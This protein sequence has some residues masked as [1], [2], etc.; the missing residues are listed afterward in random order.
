MNVIDFAANIFSSTAALISFFFKSFS[1][2]LAAIFLVYSLVLVKQTSVMTRVLE[3]KN[4]KA[5]IMI[6]VIQTIF[7]FI[8]LVMAISLI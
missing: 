3:L 4:K 7:A 2:V 5:Y 1:I 6:S 8:L